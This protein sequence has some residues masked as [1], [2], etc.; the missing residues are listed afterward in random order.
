MA[1]VPKL[2]LG[3]SAEERAFV[4]SLP[5]ASDVL[6]RG[7]ELKQPARQWTDGHVLGNGDLGA[8]VWGDAEQVC[9]GLSKH[10]V[11]DLRGPEHGTRW[12]VTY[13]ELRRR[14]MAGDRSL[15]FM[16][17]EV[18]NSTEWSGEYPVPLPCGR[19][20][21]E[22]QRGIQSV[23]FRQRLSFV[24]GE[25]EMV[26]LPTPVGN[27]MGMYFEPIYLR[28]YVHAETNVAL[29][30]LSCQQTQRVKWSFE[31]NP[32]LRPPAPVRYE[33]RDLD[34]GEAGVAAQALVL[35]QGYAVAI[36]A[37][38][39]AF[40]T[41][42]GELGL[43]GLV[44][45]GGEAGTVVLA[46]SMA[47]EHDSGGTDPTERAL[48][49][50]AAA[51]REEP[52][53][54]R[55]RH[56]RWWGN[57]WRAAQIDYGDETVARTWYFGLY[58]LGACTRPETS[59][60]H[61]QGLWTQYDLP[62]WHGDFHFNAN[63][64]EAQW[65]PCAANHPELQAALVR[66]LL[67]DWREELR[68]F[69]RE[70]FEAPGVSVPYCTDWL[71]RA[72]GGVS[73]GQQ[74]SSTA[75]AASHVW[76]QWLYTRDEALLQEIYP[77]F[78]E[79]CEFY[80][81]VM[82]KD[83]AGQYN[84]EY[85]ASPEQVAQDE[86]GHWYGVSGR[87]G[88]IDIATCRILFG[89][90]VEAAARLG[91]EEPFL[92]TV[93]EMRDHL[94]PLPTNNGVLIDLET[95]FF[96]GGDAPGQFPYSHRHPSRLVPIWPAGEIGLHSDPETLA[97]GRRSF[98]EFRSYGHSNFTGWSEAWQAGIAAHLGL[99]EE[100]EA[101]L[102]RVADYY[103]LGGLLTSHDSLNPE[104]GMAR[105]AIFQAEA[106][107]GAAAA[108]TEMLLQATGGILRVFPAVPEGRAA[109]FARLRAPGA[110]LVSA[111][112]EAGGVTEVKIEAGEE[113][114][115]ALAN[116]WG[117]GAVTIVAE[118]RE[119]VVQGELLRWRV[120]RGREYEVRRG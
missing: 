40:R 43:Q 66:V 104:Y 79:C 4:N 111:R 11:N 3:P 102:H 50:L 112:R 69:S 105:G 37:R 96:R 44:E 16:S 81:A 119:Q 94:P 12:T 67:H 99:G 6:A 48:E 74:L 106:Q 13:P 84:F 9:V 89:A 75:W 78:K 72:I 24:Q 93:R 46:M 77:F 39:G 62:P 29:V 10:D 18:G 68:R 109:A 60:P 8:V 116:P 110:H 92:E 97:L 95:G 14:V 35:Q 85:T 27:G 2:D 91:I 63:I 19:L 108:V 80:Q 117:E 101:A 49:L 33:V 57:F 59:P 28:A 58:S 17:G 70:C 71:G 23:G 30:E 100:A 5:V 53:A 73:G 86:E 103:T 21:I 90:T 32:N 76:W 54:L 114:E 22:A 88:S 65:L 47:T 55:E 36:G 34:G 20:V 31:Q 64:Q 83:E 7:H 25:C 115:I 38:G 26:A 51:L 107:Y 113:G 82:V 87:N 42:A 118:G 52:A 56:R 61:L 98:A 1:D 45:F 120:E 41:E 15:G